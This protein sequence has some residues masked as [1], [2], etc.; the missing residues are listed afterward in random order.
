ML[1][2]GVRQPTRL[3]MTSLLV[4]HVVDQKVLK[5]NVRAL[6]TAR[7]PA[8]FINGGQIT[9]DLRNGCLSWPRLVVN[10]RKLSVKAFYFIFFDGA[11]P[12]MVGGM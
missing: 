11:A 7:M 4:S 12:G 1:N 9:T 10:A 5:E 6:H 2:K 3:L 8:E